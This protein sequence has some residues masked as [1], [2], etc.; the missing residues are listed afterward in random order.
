[1]SNCDRLPIAGNGHLPGGGGGCCPKDVYFYGTLIKPAELTGT[2]QDI[3]KCTCLVVSKPRWVP[4]DDAFICYKCAA[5]FTAVRRKHHCRQ[6]GRVFCTQ[7]CNSK[8][9]LRHL[10]YQSLE[11]VCVLCQAFVSLMFKAQSSDITPKLEAVTGFEEICRNRRT[12]IPFIEMGGVIALLFAAKEKDV[13]ITGTFLKAVSNL[14]LH[15]ALHNYLAAVGTIKILTKKFVNADRNQHPL[16]CDIMRVVQ[17]LCSTESA[18][19]IALQEGTVD[20]LVPYCNPN[21]GRLCLPALECLLAICS[22]PHIYNTIVDNKQSHTLSKLLILSN[23]EDERVQDTVLQI[24]AQI[25]S[26]SE[27][28]RKRLVE[29]DIYNGSQLAEVLAC[30]PTNLSIL[31][32]VTCLVANLACDEISQGALTNH[33]VQ[34]CRLLDVLRGE[35]QVLKHVSRGLANFA[36]FRNNC[37]LLLQSLEVIIVKLME[38]TD[39]E[40][41]HYA[42][43]IIV[44]LLGFCTSSCVRIL[45]RVGSSCFLEH[46]GSNGEIINSI[47]HILGGMLPVVVCPVL[48]NST[49]LWHET[50]L[51]DGRL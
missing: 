12:I 16:L 39:L 11:K 37:E 1:M 38:T 34:M 22:H 30:R 45:E 46:L 10:S 9:R 29:E 2:E 31:S 14:A 13:R 44:S 35:T 51:D 50:S 36:K 26:G 43:L 6:C 28:H 23:S 49:S 41:R 19:L 4:D 17:T 32:N 7:C 40:V 15:P 20:A 3:F 8:M 27:R 48:H 21:V 5:K 24:L 25:S 33:L 42:C 47:G 18:K